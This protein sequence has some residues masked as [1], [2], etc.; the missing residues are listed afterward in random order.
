M[1]QIAGDRRG[2]LDFLPRFL[3]RRPRAAHVEDG[4]LWMASRACGEEYMNTWYF[5]DSG[6]CERAH[7]TGRPE[8]SECRP[9]PLAAA[10]QQPGPARTEAV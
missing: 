2:S 10:T 8:P 1:L 9:T 7:P 4:C 3:R 5:Q 6:K